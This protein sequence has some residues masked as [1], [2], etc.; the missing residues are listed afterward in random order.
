MP[1]STLRAGI[2][3]E[4]E[5]GIGIGI[6]S[7]SLDQHFGPGKP[8]HFYSIDK[9]NRLLVS[10]VSKAIDKLKN[11]LSKFFFMKMKK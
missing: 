1:R 7:E 4:S 8:W 11:R 10:R 9:H 5:S 6:G 3:S 2:G